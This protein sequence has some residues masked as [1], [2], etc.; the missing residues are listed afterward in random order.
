MKTVNWLLMLLSVAALAPGKTMQGQVSLYG[1]ATANYLDSGPYTDFLEGGTAGVL[2]DLGRVWHNRLTISANAQGNFVF[3]TATASSGARGYSSSE[4]YNAVTIGSRVA[5]AP[6]WMKLAP[7]AQLNVGFAR[8]QDPTTHSSTDSVFG[9]QGGVTR[10]LTPRFDA[11]V[12]YSYSRFGY[13]SDFYSPQTFS[14]GVVYH[15][16][17]R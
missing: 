10:Q 14:V 7:Y 6:H 8:Y 15:L 11:M 12:D 2:V 16:V 5:F 3:S 17:K 9:G 4:T 1:E 13:M